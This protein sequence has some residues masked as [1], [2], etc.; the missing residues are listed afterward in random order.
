[1]KKLLSMVL[2]LC[3]LAGTL[4]VACAEQPSRFYQIKYPVYIGD[5]DTT[6]ENPQPLFFFDDV[7][8]LPW[9][10]MEELADF[11][12]LLQHECFKQPAYQL[13]YQP[14]GS[15]ITLMRENGYYMRVDFDEDTIAFNDYNAFLKDPSDTALLD[16]LSFSG[17]SDS[18][19][20]ELFQRDPLASF[21]RYGDMIVLNLKDYNIDLILEDGRGYIPLQTASDFIFAPMF[22]QC[23]LFNG[24]NLILANSD[25]LWDSYAREIKPL[26]ELYYQAQ[27]TQRSQA[28]ANFGYNELCLMLDKLYG[29]KQKHSIKYFGRMFWQVGF[30]EALASTDPRDADT[31]L[32]HFISY[33]LDDLH[34]GYNLPSWMMGLDDIERKASASDRAFSAHIRQY[35]ALRQAAMGDKIPGYQEVGNTAYVT[36]DSFESRGASDYYDAFEAGETIPDTIGLIINARQQI[37]REGSPVENVVIDLSNNT[38]GS[39]NAALFVISWILGEAEVSVEDAFTGAQST[40]VYRA[41]INL[42]RAFDEKD[43]LADKRVYCLIS[44]I[45]F[46]CGNLVPAVCKARHAV[47]L[48]GRTSGGGT[49]TVQP[50][51]TAWGT[52]LQISGANRMSFRKNGSF[53]DIDEG[54]EPDIYIDHLETLYDREALTALINGLR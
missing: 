1:M 42:D 19:Q 51:S 31:A 10:D 38:G 34:S 32:N 45:S 44:P 21:D 29:L 41:D 7:D 18:G 50:M 30:D 35:K 15:T 47:T 4:A 53:Y 22:H 46:S 48:I 13:T 24:Q 37:Y 40:M 3:L 49:C 11:L 6:F 17:F 54:I 36:F 20:A 16:L 52:V 2:T 39:V 25:D 5:M 9:L 28:L 27:P 8:D 12:N 14:E 26:G 43:T 23:A 33:Y